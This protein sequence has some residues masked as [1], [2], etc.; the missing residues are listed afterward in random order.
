M[1]ISFHFRVGGEPCDASPS[2][3]SPCSLNYIYTKSTIRSKERARPVS[4]L[5]ARVL[6][7]SSFASW[8]TAN[9]RLCVHRHEPIS[10]EIQGENSRLRD[11]AGKCVG[12]CSGVIRDLPSSVCAQTKRPSLPP[13]SLL[14]SS[15][16]LA[17]PLFLFA[18]VAVRSSIIRV[19][20]AARGAYTAPA[21]AKRSAGGW[22]EA[23]RDDDDDDD[24]N[25]VTASAIVSALR[26][27]GSQDQSPRRRPS[28]K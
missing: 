1:A 22:L 4:V 5:F 8:G 19:R 21:N 15:S 2:S 13:H 12:N 6:F 7:I 20:M 17:N 18:P 16:S 23:V 3:S 24:V 25:R 27:A 28:Q 26:H 11:S 14:P 9:Y 10:V